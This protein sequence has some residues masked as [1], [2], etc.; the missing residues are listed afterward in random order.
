MTEARTSIVVG[1]AIAA[2]TLGFGAWWV[3]GLDR[4][5]AMDMAGG[6]AEMS[7]EAPRLPPV[8]AYHDGR[9]I[10]FVHPEV[11]DPRIAE[12]LTG[13]MGS[14]VLTVPALAEVPPSAT[15]TVYVFT[16]GI[17]PTDTP[18]GPLGYQPDVFDSAP[19]DPG[20]TPLR[21][22]VEVTWSDAST[23]RLLTSAAEILDAAERD[24]V[25]LTHTGVVVNAPLLTWPGGHR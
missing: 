25:E 19:G 14:P 5:T 9:P 16:N 8:F 24:V 1:L 17:T 23:A 12:V 18:A 6:A 15:G 11:S 10:A 3:W 4:G 20:Y 22:I 13:M 21:R 2:V 7:P